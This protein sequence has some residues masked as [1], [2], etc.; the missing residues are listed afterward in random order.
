[1]LVHVAVEEAVAEVLE[2]EGVSDVHPRLLGSG[3]LPGPPRRIR[4]SLADQA[5]DRKTSSVSASLE[6]DMCALTTPKHRRSVRGAVPVVEATLQEPTFHRVERGH[7][8]DAVETAEALPR[9]IG[10]RGAVA[11]PCDVEPG[12]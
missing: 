8:Y 12:R 9:G 6:L 1:A 3:E 10:D 2:G 5:L 11:I 7:V 4:P